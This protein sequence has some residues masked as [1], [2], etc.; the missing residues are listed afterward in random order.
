MKNI[1]IE[2]RFTN[3]YVE[4]SKGNGKY[5]TKYSFHGNYNQA[6]LYYNG[7]NIGLPYNKRLRTDT[8]IIANM[9]GY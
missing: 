5:K 8:H 3:F 2:P 6:V 7:I 9:K 1:T 4:I